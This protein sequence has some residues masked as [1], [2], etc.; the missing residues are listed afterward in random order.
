MSVK[1]SKKLCRGWAGYVFCS[2]GASR[3]R[4]VITLV[5]KHLQFKCIKEVKDGG[6]RYLIILADVQ[7]KKLKLANSY[8]S[9][10]DDPLY[11]AHLEC[12]LIDMGGYPIIWTGDM[13]IVTDS[14]LDRSVPRRTRP[15][16]SLL[17]IKKPLSSGP[18]GCLAAA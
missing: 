14:I 2:P 5:S 11:F 17:P 3:S 4:G 8:A 10:V 1:D 16:K 7:G 9:N 12:T 13:N 15:P 6:G 18:C